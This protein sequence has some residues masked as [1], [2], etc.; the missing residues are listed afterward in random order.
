MKKHFNRSTSLKRAPAETA[1]EPIIE[2][3]YTA[4]VCGDGRILPITESIGRRVLREIDPDSREGHAL[5]KSGKVTLW[6][7]DG[8]I[9]RRVPADQI[10]SEM[11][12]RLDERRAEH[13]R[14]KAWTS[15]LV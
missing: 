9:P 3:A 10:L 4:H 5:L 8:H 13:P 1:L 14:N 2:K 11:K 6:V 7:E 15:H 12:Q